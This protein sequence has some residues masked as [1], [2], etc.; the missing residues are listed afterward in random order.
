MMTSADL[1]NLRASF[2]QRPALLVLSTF[3]VPGVPIGL[4]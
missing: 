3:S 2:D 1:E 4:T